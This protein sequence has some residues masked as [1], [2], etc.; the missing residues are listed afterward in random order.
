L[1]FSNKFGKWLRS[2]ILFKKIMNNTVE[3][4]AATEAF[5]GTRKHLKKQQLRARLDGLYKHQRYIYDITRKYYLLGR[6]RMIAGLD[7]P[8]DGSVLELGCGT[9]R[10]LVLAA[11][12]FPDAH[13]YG[14]DLSGEMLKAAQRK[15]ARADL[16][17]RIN[18]AYG[19][20]ADF[21]AF[22]LFGT[23]RFDRVFISYSLSMIPAW[24]RVIESA[25]GVLARGGS[26]HVIDFGEQQQLP[27]W[28]RKTLHAWLGQF[29]VSPRPELEAV[30]REA[31]I[32][33]FARLEFR[34]LY[35]DYARYGVITLD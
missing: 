25:L 9:A 21:D 22:Q 3:E 12:K 28:S 14:L 27:D 11:R 4:I 17:E 35:R 20:A 6:D 7:V 16:L 18:L 13:L 24:E 5:A 32:R 15:V 29:H 19:D 2:L 23:S 34:S 30:M 10:N 33:R 26:L 8:R 1:G 31:A